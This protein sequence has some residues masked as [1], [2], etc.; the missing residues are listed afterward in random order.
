MIVANHQLDYDLQ[1]APPEEPEHITFGV[2]TR[3]KKMLQILK[4]VRL[5]APTR[6]TIL[7]TGESGTGKELLARA[8]HAQSQLP[9]GAFVGVNCAAIPSNLLESELFGY[10][11]GAF[12]G[13]VRTRR[14][15]FELANNGTVLLD[16]I[17]E[18]D[19]TLQA[20][21]LRV[22]QEFEV[23]RLGGET[24]IPVD[25]RVVATTNCELK[26]LVRKGLFRRDLYYRI[27]VFPIRL[28]PLR[29]RPDDIPLL[30]NHF[31]NR[32]S[33]SLGWAIKPIS[34]EAMHKLV[35]YEWPGNVRE[36]ENTIE[37]AVLL[38]AED[39]EILPEHLH[40]DDDLEE[41]IQDGD[42]ALGFQAGTTLKEME[43]RMI[44]QT[45]E[46][47]NG[48]R[49][50]TAKVLDISVRTLRNK[51]KEYGTGASEAV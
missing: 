3:N 11:R 12:S 18:I 27:N 47:E 42:P 16:E 19:Q 17:S 39:P 43:K 8:I 10:E 15:K 22:L 6:T 49:T 38:S 7:I 28:P 13:A 9:D 25:C 24:T 14:G 48:N 40:L 34:Q 29:E 45:L 41:L 4:T 50:R 36:L 31:A 20:K 32:A 46:S 2:V 33:A 44:I 35:K 51:L 37:R 21:L 26:D 23:D 5:V 30:A 1:P